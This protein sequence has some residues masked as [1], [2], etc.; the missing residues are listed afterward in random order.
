MNSHSSNGKQIL[1]K[2]WFTLKLLISLGLLAYLVFLVDWDQVITMYSQS[3][4]L[5]L[6]IA[7][8]LL[9][10]Q[11][12]IGS[13]RWRALLV[14]NAIQF[15]YRHA[16]L[17]YLLG[18]FYGIFLPGV[19]GGDAIRVGVLKQKTQCSMGTATSSVILERA[20]GLIAITII[21]FLT[22][23]LFPETARKVFTV[24]DSRLIVVIGSI[25]I[26]TMLGMLWFTRAW[27]EQLKVPGKTKVESFLRNSL[28]LLSTLQLRTLLLVLILAGLFQSMGILI[29]FV[30][31]RGLNIDLPLSVYFAITPLIYFATILPISMGGLGVREGMLVILLARFGIDPSSAA[32]LSFLIYANRMFVGAIGGGSQ[33]LLPLWGQKPLLNSIKKNVKNP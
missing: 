33:V 5:S 30:L 16:Y 7:P 13:F 24:G 10:V 26:I 17:G 27:R 22:Y 15:K 20:C 28:Y 2:Y 12:G 21:A 29:T 23:T 31:A 4:K 18:E 11:L 19:L 8:V 9:F 32:A 25:G 1:N 14:D 3:N 6:V